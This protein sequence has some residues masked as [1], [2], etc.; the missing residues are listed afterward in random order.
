MTSGSP[1]WQLAFISFAAVLILFE[2]LRGWRR[3]VARQLA[4]LGALIAAYFTAV[5]AGSFIG[6]FLRPLLKMPDF[7]MSILAGAVLGALV[8]FLINGL[9][10][11]LFKRTRQYQSTVI[12]ILCGASGAVLGLFFGAFLVWIIIF[13]IRSLGS[14]AE[15]QV[16]QEATA[17]ATQPKVVHAVDLRRRNETSDDAATVMTSLARLKNSVELGA[18]GNLVKKTDVVPTKTYETLEKIVRV[19]SD[20]QSAQR[21]LSFPGVHE[22]SEHPKIVALRND[23]EISDM[24]LQL[25][26]FD[27]LQ[28]QKIRDA[29]N[30]HELLEELKKFD[31]EKAL[32]YALGQK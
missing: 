24:I 21:F 28:N 6:P 9:G 19:S 16:K 12:R 15:G 4:R 5:Y 26:F 14:V 17:S 27:L 7:A 20:P 18:F 11:M 8:Y 30:D 3:G 25:R 32:D 31:L 22:L 29:A 13:G 2:V 1:L 10:A 23:P